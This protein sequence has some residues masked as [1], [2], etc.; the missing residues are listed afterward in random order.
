M[1]IHNCTHLPLVNLSLSYL[2]AD[3]DLPSVIIG[4]TNCDQLKQHILFSR[5]GPLPSEL[6]HAI[7][8]LS[9]VFPGFWG[10]NY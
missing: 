4:L 6:H 2:R 3:S 1:D 9:N 7:D 10:I 5:T 8:A